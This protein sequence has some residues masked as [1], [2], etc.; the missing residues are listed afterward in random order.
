MFN[1]LR[2]H[3]LSNSYLIFETLEDA[4]EA[5]KLD[6]IF[7]ENGGGGGKDGEY[8]FQGLIIFLFFLHNQTHRYMDP[9]FQ[10][11]SRNNFFSDMLKHKLSREFVDCLHHEYLTPS[12]YDMMQKFITDRILLFYKHQ[13]IP[14]TEE[15]FME[16]NGQHTLFIITILAF[17]EVN[18]NKNH[19]MTVP[20]TELYETDA[21]ADYLNK[22]D[23]IK[24]TKYITRAIKTRERQ[25]LWSAQDQFN[26]FMNCLLEIELLMLIDFTAYMKKDKKTNI[27]YFCGF[28]HMNRLCRIIKKIN[29]LMISRREKAE[30][31]NANAKNFRFIA[32]RKTLDNLNIYLS[33]FRYDANSMR[34][35]DFI[36]K[37]DIPEY[38]QNVDLINFESFISVFEY[39]AEWM[40][41]RDGDNKSCITRFLEQFLNR[42][43][44]RKMSVLSR[45]TKSI[46]YIDSM[47]SK[48]NHNEKLAHHTGN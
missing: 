16:H 7:L 25:G 3:P 36:D 45:I 28:E 47:K 44:L 11:G 19:M 20:D 43:K 40:R 21:S 46:E 35:K 1:F 12:V 37:T 15:Y 27:F 9:I 18:K 39:L 5:E 4:I 33:N 38:G 41:K 13:N 29:I 23:A 34:L 2:A 17:I 26:V 22:H 8:T 31:L 24:K 42:S 10:L 6:D 30:F 14:D 32:P 48:N